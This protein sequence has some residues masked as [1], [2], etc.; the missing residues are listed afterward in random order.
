MFSAAQLKIGSELEM[1]RQVLGAMLTMFSAY[2]C[3]SFQLTPSRWAAR[4]TGSSEEL[5][6]KLIRMLKQGRREQ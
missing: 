3:T 4:Q 1:T 6:T 5:L 2:S